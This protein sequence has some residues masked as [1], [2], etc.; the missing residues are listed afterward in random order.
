VNGFS[1]L[2]GNT[3]HTAIPLGPFT[4]EQDG[5]PASLLCDADYPVAGECKI[6]HGPIRLARVMQMDWRH[7]PAAAEI[8]S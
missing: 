7:A 6:C 1:Y 5:E 3:E 2:K 8:T 4:R